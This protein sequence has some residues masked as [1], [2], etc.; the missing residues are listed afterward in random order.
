MATVSFRQDRARLSGFRLKEGPHGMW[1]DPPSYRAGTK[2]IGLYYDENKIR[3]EALQ[4]RVIEE[5]LQHIREQPS[6]NLPNPNITPD[7]INLDD[8]PF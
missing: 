2:W 7:E 5:Y 1:L 6:S 8:I 4:E 3:F